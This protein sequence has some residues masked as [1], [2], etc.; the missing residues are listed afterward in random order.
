MSRS[1]RAGSQGN[2]EDRRR[3][4]GRKWGLES[5]VASRN[6]READM[7]AARASWD[8]ALCDQCS[9]WCDFECRITGKALED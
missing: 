8:A 5:G 9:F 2:S 7:F 3:R 1:Y 4:A 6:R